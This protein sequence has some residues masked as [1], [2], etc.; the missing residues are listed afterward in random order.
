WEWNFGD[1]S[2]PSHEANPTHSYPRYGTYQAT[3]KVTYADGEV[4]TGTIATTAGCA[5]PDARPTVWMLDKNTGVANH[6]DA[7]ART[8]ND[9]I[10]DEGSWS[11][12][13]EFVSHVA[14]VVNQL[15][16][17]SVISAVESDQ[18]MTA[19]GESDVGKVAG[20]ASIF[21]G[22]AQSLADWRQAPSGSFS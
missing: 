9:L 11:N 19:A 22:T 16:T 10:D 13:G 2:A 6:A 3:L 14:G 7:G 8:V 17:D 1:G 5:A 21:D 15:R 12:H 18:L 20:Y 4:D